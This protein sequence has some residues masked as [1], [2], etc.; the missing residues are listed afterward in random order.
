[1]P[2][3]LSL[4]FNRKLPSCQLGQFY[5]LGYNPKILIMNLFAI[6]KWLEIK[7]CHGNSLFILKLLHD[8]NWCTI[9]GFLASKRGFCIGL[10]SDLIA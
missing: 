10:K 2:V 9:V 1:M 7:N 3:L 8:F 6:T 4:L 5:R